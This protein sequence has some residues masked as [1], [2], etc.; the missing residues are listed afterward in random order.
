MNRLIQTSVLFTLLTFTNIVW[1]VPITYNFETSTPSYLPFL[2]ALSGS[3]VGSFQYDSETPTSG[4]IT[5]GTSVDGANI[6]ESAITGLIGSINGNSFSD[7]SGGVVIGND[8][9]GAT[10]N[11]PLPGA[12]FF[13]LSFDDINGP[14]QNIDG[15]SS[16]DDTLGL[17]TLI[18]VRMFWI[19]N[20]NNIEGFLSDNFLTDALPLFS[21]SRLALDFQDVNGGTTSL[22]YELQVT[23]AKVNAPS[24]LFLF[25]TSVALI[26]FRAKKKVIAK[27]HKNQS[28][29]ALT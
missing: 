27:K 12:D 16:V 26:C 17:L 25:I 1:S 13:L 20:I 14:A 9:F 11:F 4:I 23:A 29:V 28:R 2:P 7:P 21:G 24:T 8:A 6:Y 5:G 18:N 10:T 19:E 3:V 15:F 22:F